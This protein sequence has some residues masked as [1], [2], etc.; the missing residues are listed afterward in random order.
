MP[1]KLPVLRVPLPESVHAALKER[2]GNQKMADY[3]RGLIEADLGVKVEMKHGGN[4]MNVA[5]FY[6]F[7][8]HHNGATRSKS[9]GE[10][11]NR[12]PDAVDGYRSDDSFRP[13]AF[14]NG[15]TEVKIWYLDGKSTDEHANIASRIVATNGGKLTIEDE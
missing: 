4:R 5:K 11:P 3:V 10:I 8:N 14:G 6:T 2:M 1:T 9:V 7:E 12:E 15:Y 13:S